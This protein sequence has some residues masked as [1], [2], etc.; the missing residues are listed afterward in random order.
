MYPSQS[1]YISWEK[2]MAF[3]IRL[4]FS[5]RGPFH[6]EEKVFLLE[7]AGALFFKSLFSDF[8]N[9]GFFDS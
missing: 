6:R 1:P 7:R 2:I 5:I 9:G 3:Y 4:S 8:F